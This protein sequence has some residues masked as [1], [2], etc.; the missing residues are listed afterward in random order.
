MVD[1]NQCSCSGK[2]LTKLLQPAV[3]TVLVDGPIHGYLVLQRLEILS[4]FRRQ[5][6]DASGMYRIL[7][8]MEK[9]GFVVASWETSEAG[10]A[11]KLYSLTEQG[12]ACLGQWIGTLEEY[13]YDLDDLIK[14]ARS[15]HA[16][17]RNSAAGDDDRRLEAP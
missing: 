10:P 13:R 11:K 12:Y 3:M 7:K 4:M 17:P 1:F 16:R 14:S 15:A 5:P 8:E 9:K 6:P 2:N